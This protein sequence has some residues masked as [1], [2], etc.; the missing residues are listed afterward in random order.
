M[1]KS[2]RINN[3]LH[4]DSSFNEFLGYS[5]NIIASM[6][7]Q[8]P[9][10]ESINF[11]MVTDKSDMVSYLP[12]QKFDK[13]ERGVDPYSNGIGRTYIKVGRLVGKLFDQTTVE[14]HV[15][16]DSVIESFVNYYKSFFDTTNNLT[17]IVSGEEMRQCYLA[18]NYFTI[19]GNQ[20]GTLWNSCMRH[21]ERQ[22]L[23]D[24]YIENDIKMLVTYVDV[25]G[26]QKV[27]TRALLWDAKDVNGNDIKIMDR[28]YSVFDSDVIHFK[29]WANENGYLP[30]FEQNSKTH[31]IF[32][33]SGI[34]TKMV[35]SVKLNKFIL[36]R[37]PYLDTFPYFDIRNGI[38]YNKGNDNC[39]YKL[40][41]ANGSLFPEET[42]DEEDLAMEDDYEPGF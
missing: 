33:V 40:V 2:V 3:N 30:K 21:S 9:T 41:Q 38:L 16:N 22:R 32:D 39:D 10:D 4:V 24:L 17:K 35:V 6:I 12:K 29:K 7:Y 13:L 31:Q 8:L 5:N 11:I 28:I 1:I 23:L 18:D 19:N 25:N 20:K 42:H 15:K 26:V 27:R 36:N 37:Y 34:P 14:R